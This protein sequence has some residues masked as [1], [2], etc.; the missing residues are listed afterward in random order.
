MVLRLAAIY[1][2]VWGAIVVLAPA[3]F[4]GWFG[5]GGLTPGGLAIWQC[6]GMIVGVYGVGYW[7]AASDPRRHWPIVLVGMLGKVFGP[8]GF[9]DAVFVKEIFPVTFGWTILTNDLIWWVPFTLILW[10]TWQAKR[11]ETHE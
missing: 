1:N 9:V 4:L 10:G 11:S 7:V 6:V 2:V 3:T 8:I 5:V